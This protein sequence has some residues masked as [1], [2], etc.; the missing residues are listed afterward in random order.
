M[1]NLAE[2]T[3]TEAASKAVEL[4]LRGKFQ[5][6]QARAKENGWE[7]YDPNK[8]WQEDLAEDYDLDIEDEDNWSNLDDNESAWKQAKYEGSEYTA[9]GFTA[10]R[11]AEFGGEGEGEQYWVVVSLSDGN[12]TRYFRKDGWYASYDGGYLD[13]ETYEVTPREKTITVYE[14]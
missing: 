2:M 4:L 14:S 3:V 11:E 5:A 9:D 10:K 7:W 6:S 8:T 12:T 1:T 13:G